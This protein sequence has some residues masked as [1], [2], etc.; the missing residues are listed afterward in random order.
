MIM[1]TNDLGEQVSD[2]LK[3]DCM[4]DR[5][6]VEGSLDGN[7]FD[8]MNVREG[9]YPLVPDSYDLLGRGLVVDAVEGSGG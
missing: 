7:Y 4:I 3:L 6:K 9:F 5:G 2:E 8:H 1:Y